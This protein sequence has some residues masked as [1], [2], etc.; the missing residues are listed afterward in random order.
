MFDFDTDLTL[1]CVMVGKTMT[2]VVE[3]IADR[4]A[5]HKLNRPAKTSIYVDKQ[6]LDN[7]SAQSSELYTYFGRDHSVHTQMYCD[8]TESACCERC[9]ISLNFLNSSYSLCKECDHQLIS[10]KDG[11]V[12]F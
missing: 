4:N 3:Q 2:R 11:N 9:G 7:E 6:V 8:Y 1:D 12:R 10:R 5:S